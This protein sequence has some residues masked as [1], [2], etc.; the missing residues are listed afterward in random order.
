MRKNFFSTTSLKANVIANFAGT[1][2]T[3]IVGFIFTPIYLKYIGAEGYGLIGIFASLQIVLSLLDSGL[4]TTLNKELARLNVLPDKQQQMRDLVKTLSRVY[5]II[6]IIAGVI[7]MLLSPYLATYW[8]RPES[9]S[10]ETITYSFLLLSL[11]LIFQFPSGFYTGGLLGLQRQVIFNVV[12]VFFATLRSVGVILVLV[13]ISKSILFFFGWTL[14]VSILQ[15]ITNR[16]LLW[17]YLPAAGRKAIFNK[18]ELKNIWR[19]AA[20]MTG[21]GITSVLLTQVD[22][23][24]LSRILKLDMFGYYTLAFT[25]GSLSYMLV[26]P[27]SQSYFPKMSSIVSLGDNESLK[28]IYHQGCQLAT[29]VVL[30]F[31]MFLGIFSKPLL[32]LWTHNEITVQHTSQ[33]TAVVSIAVAIHCL[34][35]IPYMLCL[36]SNYTKLALQANITILVFLIP[37]TIWAALNYGGLGGA[38]CWLTINILYFLINPYLIHKKL[39][40]GENIQWYWHDT[41]RAAIPSLIVL[42]AGKYV[43]TMLQTPGT[44]VTVLVL[45]LS[46]L[47]SFFTAFYF[48]PE[49]S[50]GTFKKIKTWF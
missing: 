39:L 33:M 2:W 36:A 13:F 31:A 22:S 30:P 34:M 3:A 15:A 26:T 1:G 17:H 49:I 19:F 25:L 42:L 16:F 23:V 7:G 28:K 24:I 45:A 4:S 50:D 27:V 8:V 46:G 10:R 47:V 43:L 48:L 6:A 32:Q 5:W 38:V 9:L 14:L 41:L 35:Y 11:S 18:Q 37:G 29:L 21:I 44:G 20:S 12:K 40:P